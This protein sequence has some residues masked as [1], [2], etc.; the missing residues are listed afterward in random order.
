MECRHLKICVKHNLNKKAT[1]DGGSNLP[2]PRGAVSLTVKHLT[3]N[4]KNRGSTPLL[5]M[6]IG[7]WCSGQTHVV[8]DHET[9]VQILVVPS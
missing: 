4:Q 6:F 5:L 1:L 8:L 7:L 9:Q 3:F 2:S